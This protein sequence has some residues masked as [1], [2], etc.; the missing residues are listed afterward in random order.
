MFLH[1][2]LSVEPGL[3]VRVAFNN[4]CV[5][6]IAVPTTNSCSGV[7]QFDCVVTARFRQA[8]KSLL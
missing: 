7:F 1:H 4:S 5:L 3:Q 8:Q 2:Y 6:Q